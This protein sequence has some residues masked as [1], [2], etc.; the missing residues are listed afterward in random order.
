MH[1]HSVP[2]APQKKPSRYLAVIDS[3]RCTG[4]GACI[5]VCPVDCIVRVAGQSLAPGMWEPCRVDTER[6]IGCGLCIR[7]PG[8]RDDP[9]TLW[10]CPWQAIELVPRIQGQS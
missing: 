6:C 4:C 10:I 5:E 3:D 9:Y 8:R 1:P 7:L 2:K